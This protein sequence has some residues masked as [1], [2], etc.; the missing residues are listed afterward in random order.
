MM[1]GGER[2]RGGDCGRR[3]W[4]TGPA[5]AERRVTAERS[6]PSR[7]REFDFESP[8]SA[9]LRVIVRQV[10]LAAESALSLESAVE[11]ALSLESAVESATQR[12][13]SGLVLE[14]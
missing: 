11:S 3:R 7:R 12:P 2:Q 8:P 1:D 10:L 6:T 9:R 13:R 14:S 5:S 4:Q